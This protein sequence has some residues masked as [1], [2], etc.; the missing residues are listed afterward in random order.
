MV[1]NK[2]LYMNIRIDEMDCEYL[3]CDH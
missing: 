1:K 3:K 2:H